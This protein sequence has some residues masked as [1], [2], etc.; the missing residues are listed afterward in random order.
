MIALHNLGA[1]PVSVPLGKLDEPET[2]ELVDLLGR[3]RYAVGDD[4]D[5]E[6][7]G[8]RWLR[9]VREGDRRLV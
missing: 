7:Y 8:Y 5:L 1:E 2:A 9:I 3:D 6:G 4:I